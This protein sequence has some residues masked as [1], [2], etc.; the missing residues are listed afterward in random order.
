LCGRPVAAR[1]ILGAEIVDG[2]AAAALGIAHWAVAAAEIAQRA[3][4]IARKIAELPAEALRTSK[5]CIAAA[6]EPG[7]AGYAYE[8]DE[9]RRLSMTTDTRERVAAFLAGSLR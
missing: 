1:L 9:T 4:E 7:A 2:A 5:L 6:Q 8:R 3:G